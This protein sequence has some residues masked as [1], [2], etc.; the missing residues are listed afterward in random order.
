[1]DVE[2]VDMIG[3]LRTGT[4][5]FARAPFVFR[6]AGEGVNEAKLGGARNCVAP[7]VN[8]RW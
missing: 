6:G 4:A 5:A 7:R 3:T 8:G 1:M 2:V